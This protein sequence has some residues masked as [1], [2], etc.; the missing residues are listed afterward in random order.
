MQVSL[1]TDSVW[2]VDN[3]FILLNEVI[4]INILF[5]GEGM[6]HVMIFDPT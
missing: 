6:K 3:S 1:S 5:R 4:P 2:Q